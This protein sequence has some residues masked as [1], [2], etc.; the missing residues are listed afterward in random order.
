MVG[1]T[2]LFEVILNA[3]GL[4]SQA[5]RDA[6][7]NPSYDAKHD[8]FLLPDMQAAVDRL[9][10]AREKQE[11]ITIYGDYDIDG[12][13]ATTVLLDAFESFGFKHVDAF[14][15]NRFVEG[16]GL[17]VDAIDKIADT[18]AELIV[19]VDCGSLSHEPIAR[20]N[21]R[22]MDVIVT[23][24][25]NVADEQPDAVAVINPKRTDHSYPFIDL[26]GVGVAFK[27]V[28][29][30]Q[31]R[32]DGL[33]PGKEKWLLDLVALGTVCDV[34]TL[35][36]ENRANVFWGLKV[37]AKT[38]R[39][40]L[41]ALMA[42]ARVEP[43]T[44][45][46]RS[47]GF[48][49]GPRMNAAGRL[50]TAQ[51]ALDMLRA[52]DPMEAL[53]RAQQLDTLNSARRS[54]QDIIFKEAI[55]QAEQFASDNVLVVS[56]PNWNHGIIGIVAAKLL[57]RFHK[58]TFVLQEMGEESKGSARSYGDY[59]AADAIKSA[60]G[61]I[62]KGGGHKL[63]AGVTMPTHN[64]QAFRERVNKHYRDQ[65]LK[66]QSALLLPKSDADAEFSSLSEQLV[67]Q[68]GQLEPF[69]NGN[70][71]PILKTNGLKVMHI[72][73]MGTE[74]QHVKLE[75][76]STDGMVVQLLAFNAPKHF[77][78]EPG[79]MISAW[80]HPDINEWMGR[81]NVEGKLLHLQ[82]TSDTGDS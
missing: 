79:T 56:A 71:Q 77:F 73:R 82:V 55:I 68:L 36:D 66:N 28:Q 13:T 53:E 63:A 30:L 23:D 12:L 54:E 8:P 14:I 42:V 6:F 57:E 24:H 60:S 32:L 52:S 10:Q 43:H 9:A 27:L 2:N 62:T 59:S 41:R 3:R 38:Q 81:R 44:V 34:V 67:A 33:A 70:P 47:L 72:R 25:H 35:V 37:L 45:N 7:L 65:K 74:S 5:E 51:I 64:I 21:E 16:Y 20:A 50:E 4:K 69:G 61:I 48:G 78:V 22:G 75:T 29:A 49:L 1:K 80:Y 31:T 17:T 40:G 58:P 39:P 15:P 76:R 11:R 19:T 46:A 26:A 18:G